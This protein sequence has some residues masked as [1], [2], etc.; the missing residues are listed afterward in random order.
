MIFFLSA[1]HEWEPH[2]CMNPRSP[3]LLQS[4]PVKVFLLW[5][6]HKGTVWWMEDET[7]TDLS[8]LPHLLPLRGPYF[9]TSTCVVS[10][11]RT[12]SDIHVFRVGPAVP[13]PHVWPVTSVPFPTQLRFILP[14]QQLA[15]LHAYACVH[16]AGIYFFFYYKIYYLLFLQA[17]A[18]LETG[19]LLT[20]EPWDVIWLREKVLLEGCQR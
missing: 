3:A 2:L 15:H 19:L 13:R 8:R 20:P 1:V 5:R 7:C 11:L 6:N 17:G 4:N 14:T 10:S 12:L 9:L 16:R 18:K